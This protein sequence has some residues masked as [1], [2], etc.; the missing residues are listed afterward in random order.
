M[1][2]INNMMIA[3]AST[4]TIIVASTG[5]A[6][7]VFCADDDNVD[8]ISVVDMRGRKVT[9]PYNVQKVACLGAGALRLVSYFGIDKVVGVDGGDALKFGSPNNYNLA[10]YHV[11]YDIKAKVD[12]GS[13]KNIG[14]LSNH[15]EILRSGP[16]VIFTTE[17]TDKIDDVQYNTKIPVIG[18]CQ[19][20][21]SDFDT[22][23][24]LKQID[25][26]GVVLGEKDR[27]KDL[28]DYIH[29]LKGELKDLKNRVEADVNHTKLYVGGI[30]I[31][32]TGSLYQTT[33]NYP[34]FNW[35]VGKNVMSTLGNKHE[36]ISKEG[37]IS[38]MPD[39]IFVD[40]SNYDACIN[41]L[42]DKQLLSNIPAVKNEK[43]YS[44][45]PYKYYNT[46][47][48]CELIN[49][50]AVGSIISPSIYP[51]ISEKAT[52]IFQ[53]F[54]PGTD[55]TYEKYTNAIGHKIEHISITE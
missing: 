51:D 45:L 14:S 55:M 1:A 38:S 6:V 8:G 25:L 29:V 27:S 33:G 12:D 47:Y 53:K 39:M 15:A 21:S 17:S 32:M 44:L 30:M 18:L 40:I 23:D 24:F 2:R 16:Q 50:F 9:V 7:F 36:S 46:N 48:D 22:E 20:Y 43:I 28:I 49:C 19:G 42:K 13:L 35:S 3:I 31:N 41:E 54:F 26:I 11:A 10:S 5:A 37:F 4:L 34:P 52:E